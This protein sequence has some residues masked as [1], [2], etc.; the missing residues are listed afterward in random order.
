MYNKRL[1]YFILAANCRSFSK[2]A[3]KSYISPSAFIKH[4]NF[5][6]NE[7]KIIL[8]KRTN[9]GVFL[10]E[11]GKSIYQDAKKIIK[12][13]NEAV[14]KAKNIESI[15]EKTVKLGTSFLK[16]GKII[17]DLWTIIGHN[18]SDINLQLIP[19]NDINEEWLKVLEN[20]GKEI[21]IVVGPYSDKLIK[22]KYQVLKI[23]EYP[24]Y[25]AVSRKHPLANK[26][27]I[28]FSDLYNKNL[29]MIER[30]DSTSIDNLRDE[31]EKNHKLIHI[32]NISSYD[33]K[34]FNYCET[35]NSAM[36]TL[37]IWAEFHPAL[38]TIPCEWEYSIPYGIIY[39]KNP[40]KKVLDFIK[41]IKKE[42][43]FFK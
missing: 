30:E 28:K 26:K 37:P 34:T 7:L 12:F 18:Y 39:S 8:F 35:S 6:E 31:I 11:A 24:I 41:I 43:S 20:L 1:E 17:A 32:E 4:I 40:R 29:L 15:E 42:I 22:E 9:Q 3:E 10:T 27:I 38:I 25:C 23:K 19:F 2:A 33:I 14:K 13:S 16:Q 5:L 21:D 36:L